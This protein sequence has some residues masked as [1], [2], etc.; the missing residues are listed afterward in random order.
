M[1]VRVH[2]LEEAVRKGVAKLGY[3]G[4][5]AQI[6]GDVLLYAQMR[7]NNQGISKIATGGVPKATD[8]EPF[9]WIKE[10][11]TVALSSGGNAMVSSVSAARKAVELATKSG[12]GIVAS[13]RCFTSSGSIGYYAREVAKAGF[14]GLVFVGNGDWGAV[15]PI[16]ASEGKLGTNPFAYAFPYEGGEVVF[17]TATAAIAYFGVV[18]AFLTGLS[19]PEG[20]AVDAAGNPT[21]DPAAVL[22]KGSGGSEAVAGAVVPFAGHRGYGL[23]ILVQ[24]LGGAFVTAGY[25]GGYTEDGAGTVIFALDPGL[26]SSKEEYF[27]RATGFVNQLRSARPIAGQT[28][29]LPGERGDAIAAAARESGEIE[30]AEGVWKALQECIK[31][32]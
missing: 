13:K 26:F 28:V 17:D 23:S 3:G 30:I 16:G 1:K 15:A 10:T 32:P 21:T 5:D 19:L 22:G 18:E 8:I 11:S 12:M 29:Q 20:V 7:G 2:D 6:I 14:I 24:L 25:P 4:N 9:A 31:A 27:S